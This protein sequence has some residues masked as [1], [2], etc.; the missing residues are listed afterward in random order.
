MSVTTEA[1]IV[2]AVFA[3][4]CLAITYYIPNEEE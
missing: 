2:L 4:I 3:I 1:L